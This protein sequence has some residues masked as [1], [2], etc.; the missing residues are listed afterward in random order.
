MKRSIPLILISV[1]CLWTSLEAGQIYEWIDKNGV[2]HFTNEP[3]PRGAKILN[4]QQAIPYDEA[5]D[6][7]STQENQEAMDRVLKEQPEAPPA[8]QA[9]SQQQPQQV[10]TEYSDSDNTAEGVIVDP[11]VRNREQVRQYER[12][13][14]ERENIVTP[15][16]SRNRLPERMR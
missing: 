3:P 12:R 9:A 13:R 10:Q 1:F 16:P 8:Q 4:E 15:L 11:Y 5:A 7:K 14:Q 6:Q 2:R